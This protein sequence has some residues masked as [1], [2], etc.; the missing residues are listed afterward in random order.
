MKRITTTANVNL[1]CKAS[2]V[3]GM[4]PVIIAGDATKE[5]TATVAKKI[6]SIIEPA[7][8]LISIESLEVKEETTTQ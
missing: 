8:E 6:N 7:Y 4:L 3:V 2:K 1:R 5:S